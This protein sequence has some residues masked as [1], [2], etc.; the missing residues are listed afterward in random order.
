MKFNNQMGYY[1]D[2]PQKK[3]ICIQHFIQILGYCPMFYQL[4]EWK[5]TIWINPNEIK[6]V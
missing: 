5:K 6:I 2:I 3:S 4:K 1:N